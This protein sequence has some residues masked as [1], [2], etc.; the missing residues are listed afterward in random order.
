M[1][2][3]DMGDLEKID[4]AVD[5]AQRF[6]RGEAYHGDKPQV[7]NQEFDRLTEKVRGYRRQ[8]TENRESNNWIGDKTVQDQNA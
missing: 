6:I 4:L 7:L 1:E 5:M 2:K 3:F 8:A